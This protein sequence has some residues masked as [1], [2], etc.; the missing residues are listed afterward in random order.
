MAIIPN[1]LQRQTVSNRCRG[2]HKFRRFTKKN[3]TFLKDRYYCANCGFTVLI[4]KIYGWMTKCWGCGEEFNIVNTKVY[5]KCNKC[6]NREA[7]VATER[8]TSFLDLIGEETDNE[9]K[10]KNDVIAEI[11]RKAGIQ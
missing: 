1:K 11:F 5:P 10:T 3:K 6:L 9:E 7:K 4:E 8:D 2:T